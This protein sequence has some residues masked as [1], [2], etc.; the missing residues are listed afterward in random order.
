MIVEK[1][2]S[3]AGIELVIKA[4]ENLIYKQEHW[5]NV[6]RVDS[7][8]SPHIFQ[9]Q[10][11][12][13]LPP[14][15]GKRIAEESSFLVYQDEHA[16][17]RYIGNVVLGWEKAYIRVEHSGKSHQVML[18]AAE[19]PNGMGVNTALTA[20]CAEH[21]IA[22]N[23]GFVFHCSYIEYNGK[24]I[25]FTAPSG[26]GKSTQADLWHNLRSVQIINGDRA[27]IRV[28]EG[29]LFAC[30]IPFAGSSAYCENRTLPLAAIVYLAQAPQ[31]TIRKM[32][33]YE[34]FS[35]IWEGISVNTWDK[36]DMERVSEVAQLAASQ[37]PMYYLSCTPD[38]SA[39]VAL[40]QALKAGE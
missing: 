33:G 17:V 34:A 26:T 9:F 2:Y 7:V 3:F 36:E 11:S 19:F 16:I 31:T 18:K 30:G 27:V 32:R 13:Q 40:E 28:D 8:M 35:K 21:L 25:L 29:K 37:I 15:S 10:I 22:Q 39:V 38:E 1:L 5:L 14:P 4:P 24:A 12:D 23:S 20:M 6:F